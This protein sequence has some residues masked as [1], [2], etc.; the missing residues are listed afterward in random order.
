M[1]LENTLQ[2]DNTLSIK[3]F[4]Q[5]KEAQFILENVSSGSQEFI[6]E[7]GSIVSING[8]ERATIYNRY[9]QNGYCYYTCI[10][11][12]GKRNKKEYFSRERQQNIILLKEV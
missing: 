4:A 3:Q 1:Q 6:Y 7:I 9:K 2:F 8:V 11:T 12:I 5:S 10:W